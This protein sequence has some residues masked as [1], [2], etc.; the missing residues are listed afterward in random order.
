ITVELAPIDL[1]AED[2]VRYFAGG[3]QVTDGQGVKVAVID[4]GIALGHPDLRVVGGECTVPGEK[5]GDYGPLGG[6]HGSHCAGII[7]A[8]GTPPTG[9]RGVAPGAALYSFRV[10]R[11]EEHTSELQ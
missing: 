5:P 2:S 3:G 1:A 8:R 10:F 7:A 4:T 9:I 11:S 6:D